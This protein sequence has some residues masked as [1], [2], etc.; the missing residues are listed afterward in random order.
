MFGLG[1]WEIGIILIVALLL[2]GP[3]R[4]PE[5][6]RGLGKGLL[7]FRQAIREDRGLD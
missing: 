4:L 1:L 3:R 2:L 5:L 6:A 7:E